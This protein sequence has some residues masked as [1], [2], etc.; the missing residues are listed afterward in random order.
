M[1]ACISVC[2]LCTL[3]RSK[4]NLRLNFHFQNAGTRQAAATPA[5]HATSNLYALRG[6]TTQTAAQPA[7]PAVKV[8]L[9]KETRTL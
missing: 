2:T 7:G 4:Y 8:V 3:F 9:I 6:N 1:D 5:A